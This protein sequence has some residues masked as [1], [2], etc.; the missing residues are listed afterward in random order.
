MRHRERNFTGGI[1]LAG[2]KEDGPAG[3]LRRGR[4]LSL[5]KTG[6][7]K[8]RWGAAVAPFLNIAG[9]IANVH[10][11]YTFTG[12]RICG[13][14]T[15]FYE[16]GSAI[17]TPSA[18]SGGRMTFASMPLAGGQRDY[19][20][21]T[22]GAQI[23][24]SDY[25]GQTWIVGIT[26]PAD[27]FTLTK[28]AQKRQTMVHFN[29][30][31]SAASPYND[32]YSGADATQAANWTGLADNP[33]ST[34]PADV[35]SPTVDGN[36]A[37]NF[38]IP[39]SSSAG[40]TLTKT[41][42]LSTVS[43]ATSPNEDWIVLWVHID[44]PARLDQFTLQFSVA[45]TTF[46]DAYTKDVQVEDTVS[47]KQL[48]QQRGL[49][50]LLPVRNQDTYFK[51]NPPGNP[52]VLSLQE[53]LGTVKL[54]ATRKTWTRLRLPKSTFK[55]SV[56][57]AAD[58]WNN[59]KAVRIVCN[60]NSGGAVN[61]Y[62][63]LMYLVGSVGKQ[64]D[65]QG[66]IT[67]A[68]Y[69]GATLLQRSNAN[70]TPVTLTGLERQGMTW[71]SLPTSANP[72]VTHV[73]CW[74]TMGNGAIYFLAGKVTNGTA[75]FTDTVADYTGLFGNT[76][77]VLALDT[78]PTDNAQPLA[79]QGFIGTP[80]DIVGP[81][82]GRMWWAGDAGN[83]AKGRVYY[84]PQG[85]PSS[86]AGFVI[87]SADN[88]ATQKL[89][90]WND[91]LYCFT[92]KAVFQIIG[93]DEPFT[94]SRVMGVQG[95][96]QPRTVVA[97]PFGIFYQ[98]TDGIRVFDGTQAPLVGFD[99]L[100]PVLRGE[101]VENL[102]S[103][104]GTIAEHA[105]EEYVI[106]DGTQTLGWHLTDHT[107]R[108]LGISPTAMYYMDDTDLFLGPNVFLMGLASGVVAFEQPGTTTDYNGTAIPFSVEPVSATWEAG[109]R[110]LIQRVY[111]EANTNGQSLTPTLII[112]GVSTT[113]PTLVTASQ[114]VV[115]YPIVKPGRVVGLRLEGSLTDR[116]EIV[117]IG[118]DVAD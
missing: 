33:G 81:H 4:G 67:Y 37:V 34:T 52:E 103:F 25:V 39:A 27:G 46:N 70:P 111:I 1:F 87:V 47:K 109:L 13:A 14:G 100:G 97:T 65:Y 54:I 62:C 114:S 82:Q 89:I 104:V 76:A 19:L 90:R 86:V 43:G 61:V 15:S 95:T 85:R 51:D 83:G 9:Q 56:D 41:L 20:F 30:D 115:E 88:D 6:S 74:E 108:D 45:D 79:G 101:S 36:H 118:W 58:A 7:A 116:V 91:L 28:I 113:L 11:L 73:E 31:A 107:W 99:A 94:V 53:Q 112:D 68:T 80:T 77:S 55:R 2:P 63:E 10:S 12:I 40:W 102:T 72:F 69:S 5:V 66:L 32:L 18:L 105:R 42:D 17:A 75:S 92:T 49:G 117:E 21:V 38:P 3:S 24:M 60:T 96:L 48:K 57:G 84:S 35:T 26:P 59:I 106:S 8:S 110:K 16:D 78:L 29:N 50:D 98:A 64:G 44:H 23:F 22:N 93:T 71:G